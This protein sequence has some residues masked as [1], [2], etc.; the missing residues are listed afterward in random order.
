MSNFER[1]KSA[2]EKSDIPGEDKKVINDQ[3]AVISDEHLGE[4]ASLFEEKPEWI[5]TFNDNRKKKMAAMA[6]GNQSD[7]EDILDQEKKLLQ[8]LAYDSD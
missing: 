6:S 4:I 2:L 8:K 3:F 1:I 5:Q 7:W